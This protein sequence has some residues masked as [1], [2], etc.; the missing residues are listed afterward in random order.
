MSLK[1][2]PSIHEVLREPQVEASTRDIAETYRTRLARD[3]LDVFRE[4]LLKNPKT[5]RTRPE[6]LQAIVEEMG[7]QARELTT[8][9]PSRVINGTGIV[10]HTN[11]GRSPLGDALSQVNDGALHAYSDL[12]WDASTQKR[13]DR[14]RPLSRLLQL[15]TG[16][17]SG[18]IVNNCASALLL[19]LNTLAKNKDVVVSRSELVEIGGG[20]RVPEVMETSGCR[21]VEVG[22]T[23]KT[24]IRDYEGRARSK[25]SVL[26]KVHQSNFV[27][28]GF[29]QSVP[30]SDLVAL[31]RRLRIPVVCDNG[32]G[33]LESTDLEFL[34]SEPTVTANIRA[35]ATAVTF[36][37]DKLLGSIQGGVI[38]G[39]AQAMRAMRANPLYRA[40]RLDKVRIALLH[41][42]LRQYLAGRFHT[43][44][45]WRMTSVQDLEAMRFRLRLPPKGVKWVP[46]EAQTGGGSNPESGIESLGLELSHSALSAQQLK[47]RFAGHLVPILGYVRRNAFYLD[48][49][50]F[51]PEDFA[52]VQN[53][54]DRI[55]GSPQEQPPSLYA[56]GEDLRTWS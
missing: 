32:S 13:A 51:F 36:S 55:W 50:T 45:M 46:L 28:Q 41:H 10:I 11:L 9:F 27:Q 34:S 56:T 49:R 20:F 17:E 3:V 47:D 48:V 15:L 6:V 29:V 53:V 38:V 24:R 25:E 54:L 40:L 2:L 7:K 33:L 39:R 14:D 12:E 31:G 35:G 4:K 43:L 42:A 22:T 16:A 23:N 1:I 30:L 8:P 21:L 26:L 5:W 18:L 37:A 52:E 44:P 19:A